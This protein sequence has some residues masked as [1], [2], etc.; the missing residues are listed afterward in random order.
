MLR[1]PPSPFPKPHTNLPSAHK[2]P[3]QAWIRITYILQGAKRNAGPVYKTLHPDSPPGARRKKISRFRFRVA[4][5]GGN[6]KHSRK[7]RRP[8]YPN[9]SPPV[10]CPVRRAIPRP[11]G[12][13]RPIRGPIWSDPPPRIRLFLPAGSTAEAGAEQM[14]GKGGKGLLAAK[15]TAAKTAEKDKG[16]KA[17]VSRSSRAG[18]QA[19]PPVLLPSLPCVLWCFKFR[20]RVSARGCL[21]LR[22]PMRSMWYRYSRALGFVISSVKNFRSGGRDWAV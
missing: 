10:I 1:L 6:R 5:V 17:P 4:R 14:A 7:V 3:E 15:T 18:L 12:E 20:F 21:L 8:P 22:P 2:L 19:S 9:P 11:G 13:I 16:K